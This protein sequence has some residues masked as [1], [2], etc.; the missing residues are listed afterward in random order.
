MRKYRNV[1]TVV[2]GITFDSKKEAK[3]YGELKLMQAAGLISC[4]ELQVSYRLFIKGELICT[5]RA[6][7]RYKDKDGN[8]IVEDVK[9]VRTRDYIIKRKLMRA[10]NGIA[11][12]ET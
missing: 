1:K 4:L 2:D 7:F 11:I 9:G 10:I 5:Y 3:R 8:V 6:D 12:K